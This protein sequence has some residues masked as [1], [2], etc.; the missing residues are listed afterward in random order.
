MD[1]VIT[2]VGMAFVLFWVCGVLHALGLLPVVGTVVGLAILIHGGSA[3]V[4]PI[5]LLLCVWSV[6]KYGW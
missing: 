2:I 3:A 4:L 5:L 6:F 1:F